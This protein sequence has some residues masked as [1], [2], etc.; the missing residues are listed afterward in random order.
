MTQNL[1]E[2]GIT[3]KLSLQTPS[4]ERKEESE[5]T[6]INYLYYVKETAPPALPSTKGH[7]RSIRP[8]I[9]LRLDLLYP[10]SASEGE[11]GSH[12]PRPALHSSL[13]LPC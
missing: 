5:V 11:E 13:S 4:A 3:M 10:E 9:R 2:S 7:T 6:L 12:A 8:R 1:P